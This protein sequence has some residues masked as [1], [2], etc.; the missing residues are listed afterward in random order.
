[1]LAP[2]FESVTDMKTEIQQSVARITIKSF[3]EAWLEH[4]RLCRIKFSDHG[5]QQ[6]ALDF[7]ALRMWIGSNS[8]VTE[9]SRRYLLLLDSLRQCEGVAK[10][11]RSKP[12]ELLD[13]KPSK[14]KVAPLNGN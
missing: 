11:L 12:G 1:V 2:V 9:D 5:A 4:I 14:N 7:G 3:C 10:L 6:I 8:N 13:I